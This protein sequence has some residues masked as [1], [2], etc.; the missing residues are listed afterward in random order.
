MEDV[1]AFV[2]KSE[3]Y[4]KSS[5][6]LIHEGD[7]DSSVSRTYYAMFHLATA[8]LRTK[9]ITV[10][11]HKGIHSQFAQQFVKTG[12]LP[13]ELSQSFRMAFDDRQAGDYDASELMEESDAKQL[14]E[15]GKQ[16]FL[17]ATEYL[18][19]E[20]FLSEDEREIEQKD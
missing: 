18:Q 20:G 6:I 14:L 16:F 3:K 15:K 13:K 11:T 5:E 10:S 12:I 1:K 4:L 19:K 9:N 7:Y 17:Q 2:R 8:L